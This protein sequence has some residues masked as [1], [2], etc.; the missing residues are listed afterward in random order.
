[1]EINV[2][3]DDIFN[4]YGIC[5]ILFLNYVDVIYFLNYEEVMQI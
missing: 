1:M 4:I 5:Y 2:I 3:C